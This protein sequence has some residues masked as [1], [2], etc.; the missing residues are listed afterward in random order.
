MGMIMYNC[1]FSYDLVQSQT[2]KYKAQ[3]FLRLSKE[4]LNVIWPV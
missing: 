1:P 3:A 2:L 4:S